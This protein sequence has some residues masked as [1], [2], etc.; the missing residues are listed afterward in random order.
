MAS[1]GD[2][3]PLREA[4]V[5]LFEGVSIFPSN[6]LIKFPDEPIN[7]R[8]HAYQL[9][10]RAQKSYELMVQKYGLMLASYPQ[11][12][13]AQRTLFHLQMG[14][15]SALEGLW[16]NSIT[17]RGLLLTDGLEAPARPA[18]A[19]MP[20]REINVPMGSAVRER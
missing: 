5:K 20:V 15:I 3:K 7:Y 2:K 1:K 11:V 14:Y 16:M 8:A 12:L 13:L 18:E 17:L 9:L 4:S 10:P 19:D 6:Y